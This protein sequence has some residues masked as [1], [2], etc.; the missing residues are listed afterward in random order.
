MKPY[1]CAVSFLAL[2]AW[3]TMGFAVSD[4][5]LTSIKKLGELNGIALHCKAFAETQR[6]KKALVLN[7][8]KRRQLGELFDQ[9]TNRSFLDFINNR[10]ACPSLGAFTQQVDAA[11]SDLKMVFSKE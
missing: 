5:Q 11:I 4:S 3:Q 10:A 6:M 2:C 8:P 9:E 1:L 7:L